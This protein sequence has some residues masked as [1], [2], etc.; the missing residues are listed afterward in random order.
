[1]KKLESLYS[2]CKS[3]S[4]NPLCEGCSILEKSK[5]VYSVM[6]YEDLKQ[7]DVL[8]LSDSITYRF[9]NSRSFSDIEKEII[10]ECFPYEGQYSSSV[11]C[12]S[13]KEAD[14][15]PANMKLCRAHLEATVDKAQS[16][17]YLWAMEVK[18]VVSVLTAY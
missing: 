18:F 12:P 6:D 14:M 9:G 1:M 3:S 4:D 5:P 2:S 13:V 16:R 15:S 7:S 10:T 17:Q 8:F 11:K